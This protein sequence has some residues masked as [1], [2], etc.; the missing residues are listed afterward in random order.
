MSGVLSVG[1]WLYH[2][3]PADSDFN[4]GL[5]V[6]AAKMSVLVFLGF[7][8]FCFSGNITFQKHCKIAELNNNTVIN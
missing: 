4:T 2:E 6:N 7:V 8:F 1:P 5:F 3:Q